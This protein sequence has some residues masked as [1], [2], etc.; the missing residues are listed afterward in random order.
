[1]TLDFA[2]DAHDYAGLL[3]ALRAR[4]EQLDV[5]GATLD[6]VS[7]L[8]DGYVHKLLGP[9]PTK[10]IGTVVLSDLLCAMGL[11][12][13]VAHDPEAFETV[14]GR[15]VKRNGKYVLGGTIII[16]ITRKELKKRQRNGGKNRAASLTPDR[17]SEI[18][19]EGA[20]ARWEKAWAKQRGIPQNGAAI[21]AATAAQAKR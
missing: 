17:R 15:L 9:S 13:I 5:S 8:A 7:G 16:R 4:L 6:A 11:K 2:Q 18:S 21:P 3:E 20:H 19:R 10:K 14:K 1:M 12:L